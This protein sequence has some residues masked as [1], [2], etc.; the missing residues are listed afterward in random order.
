MNVI[1][2]I[3]QKRIKVNN[4]VRSMKAKINEELNLHQLS[5][6]THEDGYLLLLC[7]DGRADD[8]TCSLVLFLVSLDTP[9]PRGQR[10]L[11]LCVSV[12]SDMQHK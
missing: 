6:R 9:P 7:D 4:S 12:H 5:A 10:S 2:E 3:I 8:E 11:G 1:E